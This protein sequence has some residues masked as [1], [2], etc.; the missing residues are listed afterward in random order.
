MGKQTNQLTLLVNSRWVR[1]FIGHWSKYSSWPENI[2]CSIK[3][4]T[5]DIIMLSTL[6][7]RYL[8]NH[9]NCV[10]NC[11]RFLFIYK[12]KFTRLIFL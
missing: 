6:F 5:R 3:Q 1:T 11:F 12:R 4:R 10:E 9:A 8:W 7:L 2:L